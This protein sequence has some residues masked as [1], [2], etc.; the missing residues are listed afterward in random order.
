[1]KLKATVVARDERGDIVVLRP[2]DTV[3]DWV[4]VTN[5][6]AVEAE[7]KP[8]AAPKA[9]GSASRKGRSRVQPQ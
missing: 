3:P 6:D 9:E 2:G 8:V 1:M 4:E 5:P 7:E